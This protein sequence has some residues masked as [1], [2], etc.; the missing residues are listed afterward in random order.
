MEKKEKGKGKVMG[1]GAVAA[2]LRASA[3]PFGLVLPTPRV[4]IGKILPE[5]LTRRNGCRWF[6]ITTQCFLAV[7]TSQLL[8]IHHN[9]FGVTKQTVP[10]IE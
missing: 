5:I 2:I 9:T 4:F 6:S 10:V 8:G 3:P 7:W 1:S